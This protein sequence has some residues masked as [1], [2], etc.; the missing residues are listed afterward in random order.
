MSNTVI[1]IHWLIFGSPAAE[2][3]LTL[4]TVNLIG[5]VFSRSLHY[6]FYVWYFYSIPALLWST[7]IPVSAKYVFVLK[8]LT[9]DADMINLLP[10]CSS[11]C[12]SNTAGTVTHPRTWA[13]ASCFC[14]T[15]WSWVAC[16][17]PLLL[18]WII[19][20]KKRRI[21]NKINLKINNSWSECWV[22]Y[23]EFSVCPSQ[24]FCDQD[25]TKL[26]HE[27]SLC[28]FFSRYK[29]LLSLSF[30]SHVLDDQNSEV[31]ASRLIQLRDATPDPPSPA[32]SPDR[33][34][35]HHDGY[36]VGLQSFRR[37]ESSFT[38]RGTVSW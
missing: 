17:W 16:Y 9:S 1:W 3:A 8:R 18:F 15:S 34:A 11:C 26:T 20:I 33:M 30:S 6:Q 19:A 36:G 7:R 24:E 12:W 28:A 37:R 35:T 22:F 29:K 21:R 31:E 23:L 10:G 38:I 14:S 2:V 4:F 5:I 25:P 27:P 13:V 32:C